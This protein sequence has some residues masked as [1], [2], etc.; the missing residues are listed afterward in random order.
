MITWLIALAIG[1]VALWPPIK[2]QDGFLPDAMKPQPGG[3]SYLEAVEALQVVRSR[4]NT[5]DQLD[6]PSSDACNVLMLG[7]V[8]GSN[9]E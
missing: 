7:L 1:V 3:P 8:A 9:E 6:Q 2:K 5:T 4:L